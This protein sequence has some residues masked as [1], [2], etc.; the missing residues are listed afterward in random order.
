MSTDLR[1]E[2]YDTFEEID[3]LRNGWLQLHAKGLGQSLHFR[4]FPWVRHWLRR[5][6]HDRS[7]SL[8][9]L[10]GFVDDRLVLVWPLM[11]RSK[12][13]LRCLY[14]LGEPHTQY[15]DVLVG[16]KPE[17]RTIVAN[18]LEY[19][20]RTDLGDLM[21]LR[22]VRAESV[23]GDVLGEVGHS[24]EKA[25]EVPIVNL[26]EYEGREDY[27]ADLGKAVR[28]QQRRKRKALSEAGAIRLRVHERGPEA[29]K[30]VESAFEFKTAW[31]KSKGMVSRAIGDERSRHFW[32]DLALCNCHQSGLYVSELLCGEEPVAIE[33]ALR[34]SD[35]HIA[36]IGSYNLDYERFSPGALHLEEIIGRC[37]ED[38]LAVYDFLP[39]ADEY[40]LRWAN[41][42]EDVY[43]FIVPCSRRGQF[44]KALRITE[45]DSVLKE[46]FYRLPLGLRKSVAGLARLPFEKK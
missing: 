14:W 46:G 2:V 20:R 37:I 12:F 18:G 19:M 39:P 43:D 41:T 32:T 15:G 40:K 9:V 36:H 34:S 10:A 31:L 24:A 33:V 16:D 23:L 8:K 27:F 11:R 17:P 26:K 35:R 29:A 21:F 22:R 30:A 5:F 4:S 28:K 13:G 25:Y 3:R 42:R 1:F 6:G 7:L 45:I 44:G 38:G